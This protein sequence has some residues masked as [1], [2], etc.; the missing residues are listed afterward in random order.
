[1]ALA[2]VA[3]VRLSP[4]VSQGP[5]VESVDVEAVVVVAEESVRTLG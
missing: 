3:E 1:M 5:Q 2:V 4:Q